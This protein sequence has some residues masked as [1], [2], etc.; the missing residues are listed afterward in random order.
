MALVGIDSQASRSFYWLIHTLYAVVSFPSL[1]VANRFFSV[2]L[3]ISIC[4]FLLFFFK[5]FLSFLRQKGQI[6][7]LSDQSRHRYTHISQYDVNPTSINNSI[8]LHLKINISAM[9]TKAQSL[10]VYSLD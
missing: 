1:S 5:I 9:S 10:E 6:Q 4:F 8:H 3:F 7:S 2:L